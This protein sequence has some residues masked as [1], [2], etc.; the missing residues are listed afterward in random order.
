MALECWLH[1]CGISCV[2]V[3]EP[4]IFSGPQFSHLYSRNRICLMLLL[5]LLQW[6]SSKE[7]ACSA[8]GTGLLPGLGRFPG[9]GNAKP[10]QYSRLGNPMNRIGWRAKSV[11]STSIGHNL[12]T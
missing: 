1:H 6:L 8:G 11:E 5:G 3:G 7:S 10:L 2:T 4:H 9:E 12:V